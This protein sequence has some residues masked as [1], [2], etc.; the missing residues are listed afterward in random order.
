MKH[1][2]RAVSMLLTRLTRPAMRCGR[3]L[4]TTSPPSTRKVLA[5]R[6]GSGGLATS[7]IRLLAT[8][9]GSAT[10]PSSLWARAQKKLG[11]LRGF[12][13]SYLS[14]VQLFGSEVRVATRLAFRVY[15]QGKR[16]SRQERLHMRQSFGDLVRVVPLAGLFLVFGLELTTMAI[17]R[18]MPALLPRAMREAVVP[19]AQ[20]LGVAPT[21]NVDASAR[22]RL[23]LCTDLVQGARAVAARAG[24]AEAEALLARV[25]DGNG[26]Q[27][28][29]AADMRAVPAA[30]FNS[31]ALSLDALPKA[32]VMQLAELHLPSGV[33]VPGP[34]R[35][36][37]ALG[38]VSAALTPAALQR[39]RLRE[40][41]NRLREDDKE[42]LF[43]GV[44]TLSAEALH[45]ACEDRGLARGTGTAGET[46]LRSRFYSW[47]EL[48]KDPHVG[49]SLLLLAPA[50]LLHDA[51][52]LEEEGGMHLLKLAALRNTALYYESAARRYSERLQSTR[53]EMARYEE[54][55]R[56]QQ[57][58]ALASLEPSATEPA[59]AAG[60]RAEVTEATRLPGAGG[61]V[62]S[63]DGVGGR[64]A[65][66]SAGDSP[67]ST[68]E[69]RRAAMERLESM[70]DAEEEEDAAE[71]VL[72][73]GAEQKLLNRGKGRE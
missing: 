63:A 64:E 68:T 56:R 6:V 57:P 23:A 67:R 54:L 12:F 49:G 40:Y 59:A 5:S 29:S 4:L 22:R 69:K 70:L 8:N 17:L 16:S 42:I 44:A 34:E 32:M 62:P 73:T 55:L 72:R 13:A 65:G 1:D 26:G 37:D 52:S 51:H 11:H 71:N 46:L 18:Y 39:R 25:E 45:R 7:H 61:A 33:K 2:L 47:L 43:E 10:P 3:M 15:G 41:V 14:G 28:V 9:G 27:K 21:A 38:L 53:D 50:M 48:S 35:I 60:P 24:L 19:A 58:E 20:K 30:T 66:A 36:G 31:G